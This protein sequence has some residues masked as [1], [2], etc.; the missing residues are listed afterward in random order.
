MSFTRWKEGKKKLKEAWS[1]FALGDETIFYKVQEY[2]AFY[3]PLKNSGD[4][5]AEWV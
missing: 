4:F 3:S 2:I 1:Q 5:E